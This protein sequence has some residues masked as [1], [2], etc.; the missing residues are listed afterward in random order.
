MNNTIHKKLK[1]IPG[2]N[3]LRFRRFITKILV[4]FLFFF[5]LLFFKNHV[6]L[7]LKIR[8]IFTFIL[9]VNYSIL[10]TQLG[11]KETKKRKSFTTARHFRFIKTLLN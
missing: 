6:L 5:L 1:H 8:F 7:S 2:E 10:K 11:L 9:L 3:K 4:F